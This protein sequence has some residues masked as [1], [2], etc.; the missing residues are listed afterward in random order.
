VAGSVT[1]AQA[2]NPTAP[3]KVQSQSAVDYGKARVKF[4]QAFRSAK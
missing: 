1:K 4:G 2:W 3:E